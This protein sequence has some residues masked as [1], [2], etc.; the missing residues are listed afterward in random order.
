MRARSL[1]PPDAAG[2]ARLPEG[3]NQPSPPLLSRRPARCKFARRAIAPRNSRTSRGF[4]WLGRELCAQALCRTCP[5][6]TSMGRP[7]KIKTVVCAA[8]L[9]RR[10]RTLGVPGLVRVLGGSARGLGGPRAVG[11]YRAESGATEPPAGN[12]L[13]SRPL[14]GSRSLPRVLRRAPRRNQARPTCSALRHLT[15]VNGLVSRAHARAHARA[16]G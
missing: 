16:H 1:S 4:G 2:V 13:A 12:S 8:D 15:S 6:R 10:P 9:S 5:C 3:K 7:C 11:L 14:A